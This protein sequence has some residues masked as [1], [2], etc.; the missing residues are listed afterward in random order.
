MFT[1]AH[2]PRSVPCSRIKRSNIFFQSS[3]DNS[4]GKATTSSLASRLSFVFS[5][6]STASH[7]TCLSF[8]FS[9]AYCGRKTSLQTTLLSGVIV[10]QSIVVVV[11]S[12]AGCVS[13]SRYDGTACTTTHNFSFQMEIVHYF[14]P[15][16][17]AAHFCFFL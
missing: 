17:A 8:Q 16:C 9:G 6:D 5:T 15:S 10:G 2:I 12:R 11:E 4:A 14:P 13:S 7:S 1:S 3:K